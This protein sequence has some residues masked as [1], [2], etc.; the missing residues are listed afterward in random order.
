MVVAQIS[1]LHIKRKGMALTH[2]P[3]TAGPLRRVLAA[4]NSLQQPPDCIIATGDLTE[5]GLPDEYA[6]LR[7]ILQSSAISIYLV[8]GNHD[9]RKHMRAAF[10]DHAYLGADG[11]VLY[12]IEGALL[13]IVVLDTS[14]GAH[15][16][17]YLDEQRVQWLERVLADRPRTRT[18]LAMHHPPFLTGVRRFDSQPF[19][20]R[21]RLSEAVRANPQ[22]RRIICG[23]IHQL[24]QRPWSGSIGVSAPS[25]APTLV[26]HPKGRGVFFEPGGYLLHRYDWNAEVS[27]ELVRVNAE[28]VAIGA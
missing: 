7:E 10:A 26:M 3:H 22:V 25:T 17:G 13:R 9:R 16:G 27:T 5:N 19:L 11:P 20:L 12:V 24:L 23:H 14:E 4:I 28:P 2:M 15:R 1:D 8:P 21:E 6:R 18:I